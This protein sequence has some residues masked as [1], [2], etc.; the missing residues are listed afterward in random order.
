MARTSAQSTRDQ[1]SKGTLGPLLALVS[2]CLIFTATAPA[3]AQNS[4]PA[5]GFAAKSCPAEALSLDVP[6]PPDLQSIDEPMNVGEYKRKLTNFKC[7][8]DY[9][10]AVDETAEKAIGYVEQHAKDAE[11]TAVVL[12]IDET[13]LSNWPA[14]LTDDYG[15]IV[16]GPCDMTI[17]GAC[18]WRARQLHAKDEAIAPTRKLFNAAERGSGNSGKRKGREFHGQSPVAASGNCAGCDTRLPRNSRISI[19]YGAAGVDWGLKHG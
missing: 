6:R 11:Q 2:F 15:F 8:G 5:P 1:M 17:A 13:A 4:S 3:F 18:G 14:I 10:K 12:D 9:A 19:D 7:S 16:D